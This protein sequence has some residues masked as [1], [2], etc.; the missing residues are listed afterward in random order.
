M[1]P[2]SPL[3]QSKQLSFFFIIIQYTY[4]QVIAM[5]VSVLLLLL[6]CRKEQIGETWLVIILMS[7]Q[8]NK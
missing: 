2:A 8:I 1:S 6:L 4:L 5:F 3:A 7:A